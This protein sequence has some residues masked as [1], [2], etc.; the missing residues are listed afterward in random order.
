MKIEA[1]QYSESMQFCRKFRFPTWRARRSLDLSVNISPGCDAFLMS[2]CVDSVG[3]SCV[4]CLSDSAEFPVIPAPR[5]LATSEGLVCAA[6][7]YRIRP[8]TTK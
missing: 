2:S 6:T 1:V 7:I 8:E 3:V 4:S 5:S